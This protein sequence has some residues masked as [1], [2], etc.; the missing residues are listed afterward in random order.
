MD[1][2]AM[3]VGSFMVFGFVCVVA[4]YKFGKED[5]RIDERKRLYWATRY[6]DRARR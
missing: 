5:G 4:G 2:L 1:N 6:G 3:L